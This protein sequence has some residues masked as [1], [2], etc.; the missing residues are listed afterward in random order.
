[1]ILPRFIENLHQNP[2]RTRGFQSGLASIPY[3]D[4]S[5]TSI[6]LAAATYL[7]SDANSVDMHPLYLLV[8][9]AQAAAV[10]K[11]VSTAQ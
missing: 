1:M 10:V 5:E 9:T 11:A 6:D 4:Q 8:S 3:G 2:D 7:V